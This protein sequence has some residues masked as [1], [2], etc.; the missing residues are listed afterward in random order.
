MPDGLDI[1]REQNING[2]MAAYAEQILVSTGRN[3][4]KSRIERDDEA[5]FVRQLKSFLGRRGKYS[6][7]C[8]HILEL[9]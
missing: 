4:W 5:V 3:D 7:V 6:D 2:S 9:H 8:L 1:E